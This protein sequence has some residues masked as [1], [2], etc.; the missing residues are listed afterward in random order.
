VA[1]GGFE[2]WTG[3]TIRTKGVGGSETYIIEMARHIQKR[4]D[5]QVVVFCNTP[6]QRT[7]TFEGVEFRHLNQYTAFIGA[8]YVKH[9][10][11]S[12]FSE[13]LPVTFKGHVEN[14]YLVVHDLTPSGVVIPV[15][16]KL[17]KVFC[18]TEWHVD[19]FTQIYPELRAITEPFYYG[20]DMDRFAKDVLVQKVPYQFI[21]SSFPNRGL[22]PLLQMWPQIVTRQPQASLDIFADVNGTWVNN[23]AGDQMKVIRALLEQ[24][25]SRPGGLNITYHGWVSKAT[26][27][28]AW[29]KADIWFYP[30]TFMETFCLTALEAAMS[31]TLVITNDLAALQNT[32]AEGRAVIVPGD[33][34]TNEWK[35]AALKQVFSYMEPGYLDKKNELLQKNHLWGSQLS[36]ENQARKLL[37]RHIEP[38]AL[39]WHGPI[40][41]FLQEHSLEDLAA[42]YRRDYVKEGAFEPLKILEVGTESGASLVRL[43]QAIPH[44]V[45]WGL[46]TGGNKQTDP[47]LFFRN[48]AAMGLEKRML[49]V[50]KRTLT[51]FVMNRNMFDIVYVNSEERDEL[52]LL[53]LWLAWQTLNKGGH[54][55]VGNYYYRL[56]P[57]SKKANGAIQLFIDRLPVGSYSLTQKNGLLFLKK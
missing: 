23:V 29:Q 46:Q 42:Y 10:I 2:P 11:V 24:Y 9:C 19:Y 16:P 28:A 4:G 45:G 22:L 35:N 20:I 6:D 12:R 37:T 50:E 39:E 7:D 14:A 57:F 8:H 53:D 33:P 55:L 43:V 52:R 36:W 51:D 38:N 47:A 17:K 15:D 27:A 25:K 41:P 56:P 44:S 26:L 54:L 3:E 31:K 34:T 5:Y 48:A 13:Y 18:L 1:D 32:A 30:C 40:D 21:Y 49:W